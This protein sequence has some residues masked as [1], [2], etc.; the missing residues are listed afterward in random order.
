PARSAR[1]ARPGG[2]FAAARARGG[3]VRTFAIVLAAA[4]AGIPVPARAAAPA[5]A[6]DQACHAYEQGKW[7]EAADG[8]RSLLRY[9]LEDPRLEYNL[10]NSE[11][12]RGHIGEAVLHYEKARRLDPSD[13]DVATNLAIARSRI[14]DVIDDPTSA[15]PLSAW[16]ALQDRAGVAAQSLLALAGLWGLAIIVTWCG[17]RTGGFT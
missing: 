9:G 16:R 12:K 14:R 4:L 2:A 11:F 13:P 6:F 15:G 1:P 17:S 3:R 7:D 5:D 8:F 10:A